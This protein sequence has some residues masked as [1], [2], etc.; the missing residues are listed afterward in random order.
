MQSARTMTKEIIQQ[1]QIDEIQ[2]EFKVGPLRFCA[3]AFEVEAIMSPPKMVHVP[4]GS[5]V[6]ASCFNHQGRTVTVI[7]LHNKFGLPF[8]LNENKTHIILATVG[9]DLKGFW[10][11]QAIDIA[12]LSDFQRNDDYYLKVDKAY[13]NFLLR[14][15]DIILQTSFDR[16]DKCD[17]SNLNWIVALATNKAEITTE[18]T[19]D[20]VNAIEQDDVAVNSKPSDEEPVIEA[21]VSE[22]EPAI[23]ETSETDIESE[24]ESAVTG[25]SHD[26]SV[27]SP[28]THNKGSDVECTHYSGR[29]SAA[30]FVG[31][32]S[33]PE[34]IKSYDDNAESARGTEY[35]TE[36]EYEAEDT[37]ASERSR[38]PA[39]V[40]VLFVLFVL[41][42]GGAYLFDT[43][44]EMVKKNSKKVTRVSELKSV[45]APSIKA[46]V[47]SNVDIAVTTDKADSSVSEK[48]LAEPENESLNQVAQIDETIPVQAANARVFEL[49]V[50]EPSD[51]NAYAISSFEPV[52]RE[53]QSAPG[54]QQYTHIVVK[55]D[56][57]W[58]ITRRY[59]DNPNRYPELAAAS[60]IKNPHRIFPGDVIKIVVNRAKKK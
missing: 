49:H 59:L 48:T 38:L 23:V 50:N 16:L 17:R 15:D 26:D 28:A 56:T 51:S 31:S 21:V 25:L 3:P 11:D 4:L 10:V 12:P 39:L 8:T 19:A 20:V 7:S 18:D 24:P 55:G 47:V 57:L 27:A 35:E 32:S 33:K 45:T 42:L 2:L 41:G 46:P 52:A 6:V 58:H 60:H 37:A 43:D 9:D 13:S 54:S 34:Q 22:Q 53:Q 30:P 5:D 1:G 36:Y 40:A 14:G 44:A 29:S